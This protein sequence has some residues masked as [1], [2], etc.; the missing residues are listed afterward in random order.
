M[1]VSPSEL[2]ADLPAQMIL[3][4]NVIFKNEANPFGKP[5]FFTRR[6]HAFNFICTAREPYIFVGTVA[7]TLEVLARI[8]DE[9]TF[10]PSLSRQTIGSKP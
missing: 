1:G 4:T 3:A 9:V 6:S 5:E 10:W 2:I 8:R 7:R